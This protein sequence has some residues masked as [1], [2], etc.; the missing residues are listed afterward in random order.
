MDFLYHQLSEKDKE[1]I[2]KQVDGILVSFSKKL[3]ELEEGIKEQDIEREECTRKERTSEKEIGN[4]KEANSFSKKKM[5][6]N[7]P[8]KNDDFIIAER[9]LWK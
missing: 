6:E 2:K 1:E 3:N 8:E 7:A 4:T 5:F 9:K